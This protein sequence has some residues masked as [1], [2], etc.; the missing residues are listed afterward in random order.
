MLGHALAM[1]R[2]W[3]NDLDDILLRNRLQS[4]YDNYRLLTDYYLSG[5]DDVRRQEVLN[6]LVADAFRLL[7]EVY[8]RK[9]IDSS[10][11]ID[12]IRSTKPLSLAECCTPEKAFE[13]YW[14]ARLEEAD[15]NRFQIWMHDPEMEDEALMSI[16]AITLNL[17]RI[18]NPENLLCLMEAAHPSCADNIKERAWVSILLLLIEY[19][20]RLRFFP[21]I[22]EA[23]QDLISLEDGRV[24]ACTAMTCILRTM[25]VNWTS[26][27]YDKL[28][29]S[30][31]NQLKDIL[32]DINSLTQEDMS[33]DKL[34]DFA[35]QCQ[36]NFAITFDADKEDLVKMHNLHMDT[37]YSM[38]RSMYTV[39]FFAEP[40]RWWLP[41]AEDYLPEE[42][43]QHAGIFSNLPMEDLC[44]SDRY[45]FITTLG[46]VGGL[47]GGTP[48]MVPVF[49]SSEDDHETL[50]CNNYVKQA[51]RF[52]I[53][54][55]WAVTDPFRRLKHIHTTQLFKILYPTASDKSIAANVCLQC[56]AY[57]AAANIYREVVEIQPSVEW[58]KRYAISLQ[59]QGLYLAATIVYDAILRVETSEWTLRQL[60]YCYSQEGRYEDAIPVIEQLL[61]LA[62]GNSAYIYEKGVC[63]EQME[64]YAEAL[65]QFYHLYLE[66]EKNARVIRKIAWCHF[67]TEQMD[68][69]EKFYHKLSQTESLSAVDNMNF[70]HVYFVKKERMQAFQYYQ[71]SLFL[72]N[73]ISDFMRDFRPLR[74][75]LKELGIS[76]N[77]IYM[78]E[79]LIIQIWTTK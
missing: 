22:Y 68:E 47:T 78:M 62:P 64:L 51:Y 37:H 35:A 41:Y 13:Y 20:Q 7:D 30:V 66:D 57:E 45:A 53:L 3:V 50:L 49:T 63:L 11:G 42:I 55:P 2:P 38:F 9:R 32:P 43:R 67:M 74:H 34:D 52:F 56:H 76:L 59:K 21:A 71:K 36:D 54:N 6:G 28:Q 15:R 48:E 77:E 19:D 58:K 14:L 65:Q 40:Y 4:I 79:D 1:L 70:G 27:A 5:H 24:F 16:S 8:L 61:T 69:A 23:F 33:L 60:E 39:P 46:G 75:M 10:S 44:D 29:R 73:N 72:Y 31:M 26:Q 18:F 12:V 25:G 17:L